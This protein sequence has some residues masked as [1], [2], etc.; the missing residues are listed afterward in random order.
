LARWRAQARWEESGSIY[1]RDEAL[2][3][4]GGLR[5][6]EEPSVRRVG[7]AGLLQPSPS[8]ALWHGMAVSVYGG[9]GGARL[10]RPA[11]AVHGHLGGVCA[12]AFGIRRGRVCADALLRGW[13]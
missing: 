6:G 9:G 7:G 8:A 12:G 13:L 10:R 2:R 1:R 5:L 4:G 3:R 11:C